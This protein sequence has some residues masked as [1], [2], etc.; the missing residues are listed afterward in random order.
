MNTTQQLK[1]FKE[2]GIKSTSPKFEGIKIEMYK[3][4]GQPI[5]VF[6]FEITPSKFTD[7]G[8][9]KCLCLQ[10]EYQNQKR[11]VFTGSNGLME[12]IQQVPKDAFPFT[13]KIDKQNDRYIFT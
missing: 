9:G 12:L 13:T 8:N 3:I 2:L 7:K 1:S 5:I 6:Y 11:I 10:I 4:I